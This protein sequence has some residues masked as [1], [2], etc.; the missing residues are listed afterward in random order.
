MLISNMTILFWNSSPKR[1]KSGIFGLKFKDSQ[2][3]I[4]LCSKG[5][6]RALISNMTIF[7]FQIPVENTEIRHFGSYIQ[8]FLFFGE[9]LQLGKCESADFKNENNVLKILA[10]KYPHIRHFQ[11][12]IQTSLFFCE[13]LQLYKFEGATIKYDN[14]IFKFQSKNAQIKHFCSQISKFLFCTKL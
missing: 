8:A 12:Q 7:L 10:Q 1:P 4:K 13:T 11:S 3:F 2:F 9:N 6:S 5:N 14:I